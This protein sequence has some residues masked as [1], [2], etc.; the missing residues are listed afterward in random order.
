MK[1][2]AA[3]ELDVVLRFGIKLGA[4][5]I[6][7]ASERKA[8]VVTKIDAGSSLKGKAI[9][10]ANRNLRNHM[11]TAHKEVHP[12]FVF[13]PR[14]APSNAGTRCIKEVFGSVAKDSGSKSTDDTAFDSGPIVEEIA[15]RCMDA[16]QI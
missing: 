9:L 7:F 15:Q 6:A 5:E 10:A 1:Y 16:V 2:D 8:G 14:V 13:T 4:N 3:P 11:Q 12:G